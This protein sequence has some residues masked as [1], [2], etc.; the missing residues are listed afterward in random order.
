MLADIL[1]R[2]FGGDR[3]KMD[4]ITE[5]EADALQAEA[6]ATFFDCPCKCGIK[7]P[8]NCE[9]CEGY[10]GFGGFFEA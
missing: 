3:A 9:N 7:S 8:R 2:L 1:K 10:H 4:R 5:Q 6:V